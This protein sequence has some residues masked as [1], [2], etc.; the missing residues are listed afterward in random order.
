MTP[1]QIHWLIMFP[2][3]CID[4]YQIAPILVAFYEACEW[5]L[6]PWETQTEGRGADYKQHYP[7]ERS[8]TSLLPLTSNY[9]T[10]QPH[11]AHSRGV[12]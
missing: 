2:F 4:P 6:T 7:R 5:S 1:Y 8:L 11:S 3:S 9:P 10:T 12:A